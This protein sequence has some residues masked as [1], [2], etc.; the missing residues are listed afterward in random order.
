ME[1]ILQ[2]CGLVV[3]PSV[4]VKRDRWNL[5]KNKFQ[6]DNEAGRY[7]EGQEV[8]VSHHKDTQSENSALR[9]KTA[10]ASV[11][12]VN[13]PSHLNVVENTFTDTCMT[14]VGKAGDRQVVQSDLCVADK[15]ADTGSHSRLLTDKHNV[16]PVTKKSTSAAVVGHKAANCH[17]PSAAVCERPLLLKGRRQTSQ[18]PSRLASST[19]SSHKTVN[20][21]PVD[22][23]SAV[24]ANI[25]KQQQ[26]K[27]RL[28]GNDQCLL[29]TSFYN[30]ISF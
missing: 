12:V 24:Q 11:T 5:R 29:G 23:Q 30:C 9:Q 28:E 21:Q 27:V 22:K 10:N 14:I 4:R 8:E 3:G 17:L 26:S 25:V 15:V 2:L 18:D 19:D 13:E 7:T 16:T 20:K 1:R 6:H